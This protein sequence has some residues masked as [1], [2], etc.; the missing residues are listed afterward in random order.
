MER[1]KDY[2]KAKI[3]RHWKKFSLFSFVGIFKIM[4]TISLSWFFIDFLK[5]WALIG[6]TLVV[7]TEFF[8]TYIL[9][10]TTKVIK[11]EFVKYTSAF[12][13]F[14]IAAI[15]LI[16]L[17]VDFVGFSGLVSSAI[18]VGALFV[19]RY[20]CYNRIGLIQYD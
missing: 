3:R 6:S 17:F 8:I 14:N 20:Y 11:P 16:W 5:I 19:L 12:I 7:L 15:I 2:F 13:V 18:V 9:Y 10:L 1:I 4:L